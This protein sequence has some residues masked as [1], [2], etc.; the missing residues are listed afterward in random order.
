MI[1]LD[2]ASESVFRARPGYSGSPV[3]VT[4]EAGDDLVVGMLA[5]ASRAGA[6]DAYAIPVAELARRWPQIVGRLTVPDCPYQGLGRSR[7][8]MRMCS[9]AVR[10]TLPGC[11]AWC[12]GGC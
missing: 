5:V 8:V 3:V 11:A 7:L 9:S 2:A 12:G 6:G 10:M 1:Q 4:G